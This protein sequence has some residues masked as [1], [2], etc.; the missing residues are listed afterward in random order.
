MDEQER[1]LALALMQR[2]A[3]RF[4]VN[5]VNIGVHP[6]IEFTGL[7][8]EY[9][10]ICY[11]AHQKGIDF[12]MCNAHTGRI[13]P[14]QSFERNYLNEKLECIFQGQIILKN[15]ELDNESI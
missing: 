8:N 1:I 15:K 2:A 14:L 12:S 13:L 10:K 5:A 9:I 11:N 6:F 3:D 4:Y 7:I